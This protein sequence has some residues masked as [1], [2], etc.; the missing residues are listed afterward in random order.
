MQNNPEKTVDNYNEFRSVRPLNVSLRD[1]VELDRTNDQHE[2]IETGTRLVNAKVG[3][4]LGPNN[5]LTSGNLSLPTTMFIETD[6]VNPNYAGYFD[7][8]KNEI[9]IITGNTKDQFDRTKVYVHEYIHFLSHNGRDDSERVD[10]NSPIATNNNVGFRRSIG[11]DIRKGKEG[12]HTRDYFLA[13]NEAVTEQLAIDVFPDANEAYKDY[14]GLLN[15]A[16]DDAVTRGLGTENKDGIFQPWSREMVKNF[17]YRCFFKGD[18]S[19]FTQLLQK[20]YDKY[21]I[22]EQQFGLMT[23]RDDLPSLVEKHITSNHPNDPPPSTNQVVIMVQERLDN[24]TPEDYVTDIDPD[25]GP[26]DPDGEIQFGTE[27]DTYVKESDFKF[28][29]KVNFNN[30]DYDI[31]NS[32]YVIYSGDRS[33]SVFKYIKEELDKLLAKAGNE[34]IDAVSISEQIDHLL[35]VKYYTSMLSDGF[36]EFYIYKHSKI[37]KL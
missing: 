1:V 24:K 5:K 14:R 27:Y 3:E 4:I 22:S 35:F 37:D 36:R 6:P 16:I 32:G 25:L 10:K 19:N 12:E 34:G 23:H 13:F 33:V 8:N 15:Q 26:D 20:T 21:N 9:V 18:L 17:I 29:H 30:E 11:L 7:S 2:I 31:D 28:S